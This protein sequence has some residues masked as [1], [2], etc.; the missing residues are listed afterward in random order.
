MSV[1]YAGRLRQTRVPVAY[2]DVRR[3]VAMFKKITLLTINFSLTSTSIKLFG[4]FTV[5]E[6]DEP[7]DWSDV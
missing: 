7:D 2:A 6:H 4:L 5:W 3:L 1:H